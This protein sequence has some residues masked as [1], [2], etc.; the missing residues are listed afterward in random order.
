MPTSS[1]DDYATAVR[2]VT[3]ESKPSPSFLQRR[4]GLGYAE[5][6]A[7]I[8]RMER[9]GI[10][11]PRARNGTRE[12]LTPPHRR[13]TAPRPRRDPARRRMAAPSSG[14]RGRPVHTR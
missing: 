8:E 2:L 13:S 11:G 14:V 9:A 5:A 7:L 4:M 12:I 1:P 6:S 3:T 10:V